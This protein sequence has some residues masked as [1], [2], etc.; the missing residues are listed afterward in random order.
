L[1]AIVLL[2]VLSAPP[3]AAEPDDPAPPA[4]AGPMLTLTELG[5]VAPLAFYGDRGTAELT[6]PV[7]RGLVPQNLTATVE[8]PVNVRSGTITV[9]QRDRDFPAGTA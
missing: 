6:F 1:A 8:I 2:A 3:A 7:P 5:V 9:M 4:A